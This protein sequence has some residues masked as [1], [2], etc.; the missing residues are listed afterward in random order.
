MAWSKM[1]LL[2]A[3]SKEQPVKKTQNA[4]NDKHNFANNKLFL[5]RQITP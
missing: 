5:A 3:L 4:S 2:T 1:T